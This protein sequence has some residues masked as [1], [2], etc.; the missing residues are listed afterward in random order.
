M[1]VSPRKD[2]YNGSPSVEGPFPA[3]HPRTNQNDLD[4][5]ETHKGLLAP[6]YSATSKNFQVVDRHCRLE[7]TGKIY[8]ENNSPTS[9][10]PLPP[11]K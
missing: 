5:V 1:R 9:E 3:Y 11:T 4:I 7:K 2:E 8:K 6:V 10:A